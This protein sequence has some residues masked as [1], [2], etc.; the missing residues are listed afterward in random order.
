MRLVDTH[1]HWNEEP[2]KAPLEEQR[3]AAAEAGVVRAVV[4]GFD[5]PSS[6]RA[7]ELARQPGVPEILAAVGL[8]P[9]DARTAD[10]GFYEDLRAL[11]ADPRAA[12]LGEIGLDYWYDN[13]PREVQREVF[14]RQVA[15]GVGVGKPLVLHLRDGKDPEADGV[16]GQ[17]FRIL[18]EGKAREVG[19]VFHC[20]GGNASQARAALDLGFHLSFAGPLTYPKNH[21]LRDIA[22]DCPLDRILTETDAPYLAPQ[23]H[24]GKPNEPA[25]VV[26]VA[27]TLAEVRGL[28]LEALTEAVWENAER[29]FCPGGPR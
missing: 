2:L 13:S 10:E 22:R 16:Y 4:V 18:E 9:H 20:F 12:A 28:S 25:W 14:A 19:G 11:L 29:L 6:R 8:H 23:G 5:L 21:A 26:E 17:A 24:R 27:R 1:C 3:A 7:L 15:L